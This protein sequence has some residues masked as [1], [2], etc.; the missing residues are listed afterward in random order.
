MTKILIWRIAIRT[1]TIII[2][3]RIILSFIQE[4]QTSLTVRYC[5]VVQ[6]HKSFKP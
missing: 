5:P 6:P 2:N 4:I 3:L 1:I